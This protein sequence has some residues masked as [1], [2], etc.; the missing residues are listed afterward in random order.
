MTYYH[1]ENIP[2]IAPDRLT[3]AIEY[4]RAALPEDADVLD[5][6]FAYLKASRPMLREIKEAV[7]EFYA[8]E[9]AELVS[10]RR[11]RAYEVSLARQIF[12][13]FAYRHTRFS[14]KR[15]GR[16]VGLHDPTTVRHAIRRIEKHEISRPL[17]RDDLDLL[18]LR[19]S[20]KVLLRSK[21]SC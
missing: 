13:Y 9:H 15:V 19:I 12:C 10:G 2:T 7:I 8:I 3:R 14:M 21:G 20:E 6:L 1:Q 16:E 18:R 4:Q 11:H 17:L 5:R